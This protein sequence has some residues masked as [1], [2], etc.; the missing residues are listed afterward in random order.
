MGI[1]N[2]IEAASGRATVRFWPER[3]ELGL[4]SAV[5]GNVTQVVRPGG[6]STVAA[7]LQNDRPSVDLVVC[8]IRGG[9][10]LV[11]LPTP[12]RGTQ[13]GDYGA[14]L[15]RVC[16]QVGVD[17]IVAPAWAVGALEDL[18]FCVRS[19]DG[20]RTGPPVASP[21]PDGFE[22]VQ[23]TSGTTEAPKAIG[24]SDDAVGANVMAILRAL[25]PSRGDSAI[26]WL[27]L[28]HDMGLIGLLLTG[29][30]AMAPDWTG[31]G[32]VT[33]MDPRLVLGRPSTW[34]DALAATGASF[35][36][37]PDFGFRLASLEAARRPHHDLSRL[38]VAIVGGEIVRA[39]TLRA[40]AEVHRPAGFSPLAFCP[41]YGMAEF[42]LAVS[43]TRP[44]DHWENFLRTD[45]GATPGVGEEF[46]GSGRP[47][48]GYDVSEDRSDGGP[49]FPLVASGPSL[50]RDAIA[51]EPLGVGG[52]YRTGDL[53]RVIDGEVYV[54][55]RS[56]DWIVVNGR[57]LLAPT[58]EWHLSRVGG[59]RAG[60]VATTVTP[61][62]RWWVLYEGTQRSSN[63]NDDR[64][65][66]TAAVGIT[67]A[68]PD[69]VVQVER[70]TLPYTP[71]GKLQRRLLA[72]LCGR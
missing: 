12:S 4:G 56:D 19:L 41:A 46:V 50:G 30:A 33:I 61:D 2:L 65:V 66:A 34:L 20:V 10:R 62:G 68:R 39:D 67:G 18:G 1:S 64:A 13:L 24:L 54:H 63:D 6:P 60:R 45:V 7:I 17:H 47:L 8:A 59:V 55:G 48:D 40:F 49:P 71:S 14:Q 53:G 27:P 31:G 23:C 44:G 42:G 72:G 15:A 70:G 16:E 52:A 11:S 43:M 36:G 25:E 38:R 5:G 69:S 32:S 3:D 26:S 9:A 29:I 57:N 28:S 22:L 51:A 58:L 35:T 37:A 21:A